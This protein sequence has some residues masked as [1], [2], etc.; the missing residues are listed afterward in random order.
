MYYKKPI[1]QINFTI[2]QNCIF[3]SNSHCN[4]DILLVF[5]SDRL[6]CV[7]N[8]MTSKQVLEMNSNL[9][10]HAE[11]TGSHAGCTDSHAG[12][13]GSHAG[14]VLAAIF[15]NFDFRVHY[16]MDAIGGHFKHL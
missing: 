12:C 15:L 10:S 13:T 3:D 2:G 16:W 7:R 8:M 14:Y 4:E 11:C 9:F 5:L 6:I 1:S